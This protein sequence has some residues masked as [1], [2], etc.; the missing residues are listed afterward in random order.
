MSTGLHGLKW[1]TCLIYIDDIISFS[2][3]VDENLHRSRLVFERLHL[4]NLK[5]KPSKCTFTCK[6]V[7]FLGFLVSLSGV[8]PDPDKISA[9]QIFP[10]PTNV[11]DVRSFLG[12]CNYYR[13]FLKDFAKVASPL[14]R[15]TRKDVPFELDNTCHDAFA[16]LKSHLCSVLI[17]S[18]PHFNQPFH[19]YPDA[20]QT[21]LG[22]VSGQVIICNYWW[23]R[24]CR[25][26][27]W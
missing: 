13:R 25:I 11:K 22:Y 19:L 12:L 5:L 17:L 2:S 14:H 1:K 10:V 4:A 23:E 24:A 16:I 9:L 7:R 21:A 15:L 6:F 3:S 26:L 18:Y 27:W 20:S 8:S